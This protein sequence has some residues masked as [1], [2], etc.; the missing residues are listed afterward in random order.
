MILSPRWGAV[1]AVC[2]VLAG[3]VAFGVVFDRP[4]RHSDTIPLPI[5][6]SRKADHSVAQPRYVIQSGWNICGGR[7]YK[8]WEGCSSQSGALFQCVDGATVYSVREHCTS[9]KAAVAERLRF[10]NGS[11][12][13]RN[14]K[15]TQMT[16][17]GEALLVELTDPVQVSQE[18]VTTSRWVYL[19]RDGSSLRL[20]YGPDR[21]HVLEYFNTRHE[22]EREH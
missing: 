22:Y 7:P 21:E 14:W 6:Q 19:W 16:A 13:G 20:I 15:I 5:E 3:S 8:G 2:L 11:R 12:L 10:L 1:Y 4:A 9:P 17:I 18:T